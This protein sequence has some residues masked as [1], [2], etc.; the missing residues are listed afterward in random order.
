MIVGFLLMA[1]RHQRAMM[2]KDKAPKKV[3]TKV[4]SKNKTK[5]TPKTISKRMMGKA[6]AKKTKKSKGTVK[7]RNRAV[8]KEKTATAPINSGPTMPDYGRRMYW[9][10]RRPTN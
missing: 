4:T 7:V 8:G 9:H 1:N 5:S 2:G 6:M 3:M 10:K